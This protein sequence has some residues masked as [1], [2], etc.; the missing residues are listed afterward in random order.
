MTRHRMAAL[1]LGGLALAGC[2]DASIELPPPLVLSSVSPNHGATLVSTS[3]TVELGFNAPL[4]T[5][6]I[7]GDTVRLER[8]TSAL[9]CAQIVSADQ[10]GLTLVPEQV[11]NAGASY[12]IVI[13]HNLRG[14]DTAELGSTVRTRFR[15]S[16]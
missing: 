9:P 15:T 12:E 7:N 3:I 11:L 13:E 4:D 6:T 10:R 1:V 5:G 16:P 2:G 8:G 14:I